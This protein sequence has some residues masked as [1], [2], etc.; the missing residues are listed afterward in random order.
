M[1]N[2]KSS[3]RNILK[4]G[5]IGLM[6]V[7]INFIPF[8]K[9]FDA[10]STTE[11]VGNIPSIYFIPMFFIY[12]LI[13]LAFSNIKSNLN[14]GKRVAFITLFTFFFT[15]DTLLT[16]MEG[17]YYI[18]NYPLVFKLIDGFLKTLLIMLGIFYLWK[19][20]NITIDTKEHV[21]KYFKSRSIFSWTW[22][23]ITVLILSFVIYM[24]LGAIA[25]P[26]T[27]PYMEELIEIPSI[28]ENFT[29]TIL[30]GFAYL[31]VTLPIIIFWK[32]SNTSLFLN[33]TLINILLYPVLGYVFAYFFPVMF[34]IIDGIVLSLHVAA[35]SWLFVRLLKHGSTI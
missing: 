3:F 20:V 10:S 33:L 6:V 22:R 11:E 35:L 18:E 2:N 29:I 1:G 4:A 17:S 15:I 7:V 16:S 24:I 5:L 9:I 12:S 30:R 26:L 8:E 28:L 21:N 34:R 32:K 19:Q 31:L 27:G 13:A 23:F 14:L 25:F